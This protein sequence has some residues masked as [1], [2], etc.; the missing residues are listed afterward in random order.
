MATLPQPE[1]FV[2]SFA[3]GADDSLYVSERPA[4]QRLNLDPT[5]SSVVSSV[6]LLGPVQGG[7]DYRQLLAFTDGPGHEFLLAAGSGL[8][9]YDVETSEPEH[10]LIA[11]FPSPATGAWGLAL[12][13]AGERTFA[14][15][16][17][18]FRIVDITDPRR[19]SPI[20]SVPPGV[21]RGLNIAVAGSVAYVSTELGVA[22]VDLSDLAAPRFLKLQP[23]A[24][25]PGRIAIAETGTQ[26]LVVV[27]NY[28]GLDILDGDPGS[29]RFLETLSTWSTRPDED[30]HVGVFDVR[31][32]GSLVYVAAAHDGVRVLDVSDPTAPVEKGYYRPF[33]FDPNVASTTGTGRVYAVDA[34]SDG[35]VVAV[36]QDVGLVTLALE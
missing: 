7:G 31:A 2:W 5:H 16:S 35:T 19:A 15:T 33:D 29:P 1:I 24:Y 6:D 30:H 36:V 25:W 28:P 9:I 23:D 18:D 8:Q 21:A 10:A 34:L 13:R 26:R 27:D 3:V 20:V 22:A 12:H 11:E 17:G 32:H 14:I 4:I